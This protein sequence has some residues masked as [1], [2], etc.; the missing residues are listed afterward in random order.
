MIS[1][2]AAER[3]VSAGLRT[4]FARSDDVRGLRRR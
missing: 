4:I 1:A 3:L 2:G